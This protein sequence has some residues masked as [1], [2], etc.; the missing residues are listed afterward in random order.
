[1]K[2]IKGNFGYL[3]VKRRQVLVRTILYF[4]IS[5]ALFTAGYVTTGTRKNLLTVVA[6]LGCLPACKSMVQ[7]IMLIRAKGCSEET[8][9]ILAPLEGRLIGMYDLYFTSY[10]KNF[11]LSHMVVDGKVILG[12]G[13]KG[14]CELKACQEHLQTMLKQGGFQDITL[15][16]TDDIE[17]YAQQLNNLNCMERTGSAEKEDEVRVLLYEISL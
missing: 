1:M 3:T 9:K 11:A 14:V 2:A 13:E 10:Q 8:R 16:L 5:L 7:L 4:G 17:K 15:K 6:V 12:Y